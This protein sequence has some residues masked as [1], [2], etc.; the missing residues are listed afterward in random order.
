MQLSNISIRNFRRLKDVE[1][2]FEGRETLF[3]GP[4]NSGKTS[5]TAAVRSFLGN[6]DFKI[7]DFSMSCI[8]NIDKF[9]PAQCIDLPSIE[10]DIWFQVD[11]KSISFGRVFDLATSLSEDFS[12]IGMRCA[13]AVE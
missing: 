12:E 13:L 9:D 1:I 6:R 7:H 11:P 10:L 8:L 3:V 4:N 2:D 5:A